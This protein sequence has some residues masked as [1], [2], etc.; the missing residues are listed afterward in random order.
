MRQH[1]RIKGS[2]RLFKHVEMK[3]RNSLTINHTK[4]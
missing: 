2:N 1:S 4:V 3:N